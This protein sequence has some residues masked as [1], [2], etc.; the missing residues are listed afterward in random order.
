MSEPM[1]IFVACPI[2][3]EH[4][5][6]R[7]RS[8]KLLAYVVEPVVESLARDSAQADTAAR[9]EV[10][11]ADRTSLPGRISK[12]MIADIASCDVMIADLTGDNPNVLYE[13]GLRQAL[14][15]PYVLMAER[16]HK[17]PFDLADIRTI[18][19]DFDVAEVDKAKDELAQFLRRALAG[20]VSP[21]DQELLA[22]YASRRGRDQEGP[23]PDVQV[24]EATNKV[25]QEVLDLRAK[26][27]NLDR[28]T[29]RVEDIKIELDKVDYAARYGRAPAHLVNLLRLKT[30][31]FHGQAGGDAIGDV[32]TRVYA[33]AAEE[34]YNLTSGG[35]DS[36]RFEEYHLVDK[37]LLRLIDVLPNGSVWLGVTRLQN[38]DAWTERSAEK[39]YFKF[40]ERVEERTGTNEIEFYRLWCFD[41]EATQRKMLA[42]QR[43]QTEKKIVTR[44]CIAGRNVPDMSLIWVPKGRAGSAAQSDALSQ[45]FVRLRDNYDPLCGIVFDE[46]GGK[47][48]DAMTLYSPRADHFDKLRFQFEQNW[49][50]A[51][52]PAAVPDAGP[53]TARSDA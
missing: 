14:L 15:R 30:P 48:L 22:P 42:T 39:S 4:S 24:L 11:R 19:Y 37:F 43:Q 1:K 17:L 41:D 16:G 34:L 52:T 49:N 40:Q 35:Q 38:I 46:R 31:H 25:L 20:E 10:I 2:G 12:Q 7:Q 26:L 3:L 6:E 9:I 28:L 47:E 51:S 45:P 5:E 33:R 8:D 50:R 23:R 32:L 13:V 36:V 18:F 29:E 44:S 27:T 21:I 53:D